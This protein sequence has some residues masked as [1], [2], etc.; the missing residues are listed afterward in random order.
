MMDVIQQEFLVSV[1]YPV[2]F[3]TG[4]F[5][6]SNRVLRD[7]VAAGRRTHADTRDGDDTVPAK[8]IVVVDRGVERAHPTLVDAIGAY[9]LEHRAAMALSVPVLVVPGGEPIKNDRRHV[10]RILEAINAAA[11]CR[12]SYLVAVGGG[13]VLDAAG[14]AAATAH[15]GIRLIRVPTTVLAQ[16]DSAI[17]VKNGVNAFGKK[18]YLGTFAPPFAVINDASFLSTLSDRDWRGGAT[19]AVKAA[20]IRDPEFF[21]FLEERAP[22]LL[23]RDLTAMMQVIRRSAVLH[24]RHIATGGDP[25]EQ[26]SSRPLDFGHWAAHKLEQMTNHRLGHGEA[27]GIGI[28]LDTTYSYLAGFLAETEW[29]RIVQLLMA[30]GVPIY[31][32]SLEERLETPDDPGCVL[33][34]LAEFQEHLGGRLTIMLLNGIG[35]PFDVHEIRRDLVV[36]SIDMLKALEADRVDASAKKAS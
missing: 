16:D 35:R 23:A 14:F 9:C 25:F 20:L 28:A 36:R 18:N 22:A 5:T 31:S 7:L 1:R 15:R 34:G 27:V 2:H 13:A 6:A 19:E 11:L 26:G 30:L 4:V 32:P 3:T 33:C 12:H 21:D 29:R 17:G 10:E 8:L 24:L